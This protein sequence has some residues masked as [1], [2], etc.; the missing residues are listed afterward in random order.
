[1][2]SAKHAGKNGWQIYSSAMHARFRKRNEVALDLEHAVERGEIKVL[3]QPIVSMATGQVVALEALARWQHPTDGVVMPSDFVP[4]AEA[5]GLMPAI[6]QFV[7]RTACEAAR[8]WQDEH[9]AHADVG[10]AVNLSPSELVN[11][12]LGAQVARTLLESRLDGASLTLEITESAA[13]GEAGLLHAR[14]HELRALGV[15]LALD[16]FGTGHSSLERLDTLPLDV[17]K[18]AKP[19]VD[20]LLDP[21]ADTGFV[22]TFVHLAQSLGMECVAEGIAHESQVPILPRSRL[23]AGPGVLLRAADER[24]DAQRLPSLGAARR[25]AV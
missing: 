14:L 5:I 8:A 10:V 6:G 7:L 1:M 15:K 4:V 16:D 19:F 24:R 9:P 2:Y 3:F 22:D 13:M 25:V 23:H 18:I 21:A 20:R 11:V 12:E 17:L